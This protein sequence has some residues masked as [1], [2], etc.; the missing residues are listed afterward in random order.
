MTLKEV[1]EFINNKGL[2]VQV[3]KFARRGINYMYRSWRNSGKR[4]SD[5]Y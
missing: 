3:L 2:K 5:L 1:R 4:V